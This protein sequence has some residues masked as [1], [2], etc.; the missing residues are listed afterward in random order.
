MR[1]F[2]GGEVDPFIEKIDVHYQPGHNHTTMG[3]TLEA[4]GQFLISL[5]KFSKDRFLNVGPLKPEH[6]QVS[7]ISGER[8]ALAHDGPTFAEP[9]DCILVRADKVNPASIYDRKD[10][11]LE[12][13]RVQAEKDGV[14]L[15]W[16]MD[17]IRDATRC[18]STCTRSRRPSASTNSR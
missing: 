3:E 11:P 18:G 5:N 14:D 7:D 10:P 1:A 6:D 15:D 17:V 9:H 16:G 4:D 13:A 8:M 2:D 12:E